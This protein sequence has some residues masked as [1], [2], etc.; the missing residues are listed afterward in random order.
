MLELTPLSLNTDQLHDLLTS[1]PEFWQESDKGMPAFPVIIEGKTILNAHLSAKTVSHVKFV[2]CKFINVNLQSTLFDNCDFTNCLLSKEDCPSNW[3]HTQFKECLFTDCVNEFRNW[4]QSQ[5]KDCRITS[6]KWTKL[7]N[8][9]SSRWT[10]CRQNDTLIKDVSLVL[11]QWSDTDISDSSLK[12]TDL[13]SSMFQNTSLEEATP[14]LNRFN[15]VRYETPVK[16]EKF[17]RFLNLQDYLDNLN[18]NEK[19]DFQ[20]KNLSGLSLKGRF[21]AHCKFDRCL[22]V[23]TQ[24]EESMMIGASFTFAKPEKTNLYFAYSKELLKTYDKHLVIY[25][26]TSRQKDWRIALDDKEF[27]KDEFDAYLEASPM[28]RTLKS[29]IKMEVNAF[30]R[31][32]FQRSM[33]RAI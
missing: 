28:S 10:S 13:S 16:D 4:E 32:F 27:F 30:D 6:C 31:Q 23:G 25:A 17:Q 2:N 33:Q 8:F 24:I 5:L 1:T 22:M 29:A 15:S 9:H 7:S 11:S 12:N 26:P 21:L 3:K 19:A 18:F 14:Y 20:G